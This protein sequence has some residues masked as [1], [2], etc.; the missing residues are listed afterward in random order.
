MILFWTAILAISTLLYVLLDGF[1]L[2][3]GIISGGSGQPHE[4]RRHDERHR[5]DLGRQRDLA[6]RDRRRALGRLPDRLCDACCRP[7]TCRSF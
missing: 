4:A 5:P 7:S 3:V 1:D 2:G 6:R